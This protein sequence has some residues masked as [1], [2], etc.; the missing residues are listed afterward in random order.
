MEAIPNIHVASEAQF[1]D[2]IE[3]LLYSH[4]RLPSLHVS[5]LPPEMGEPFD[6]AGHEMVQ[7]GSIT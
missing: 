3:L 6:R 4:K 1:R 7:S 5:L 2:A